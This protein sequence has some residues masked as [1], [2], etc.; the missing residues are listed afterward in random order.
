MSDSVRPVS[1]VGILCLILDKAASLLRKEA[2][3]Y[4]LL[5]LSAPVPQV[6]FILSEGNRWIFGTHGWSFC[7]FL[8]M[9]I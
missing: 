9:N 7:F 6:C 8:A 3:V 5:N 1:E 4:L 2:I